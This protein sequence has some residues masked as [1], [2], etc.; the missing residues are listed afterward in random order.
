MQQ[1]HLPI[2]QLEILLILSLCGGGG[3]VDG[4]VKKKFCQKKNLVHKN[5]VPQKIGSQNFGQNRVIE[6]RYCWYGQMSP[7][8]MLPGQMSPWQ[9]KSLL[10]VPRYLLLNFGQ[11]R[12]SNSW[13]IRWGF[14]LL[15]LHGK[16]TPTPNSNGTALQTGTEIGKKKRKDW[17]KWLSTYV[18][19]NGLAERPPTATPIL[20]PW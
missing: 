8:E 10:D 9:L 5:W 7:G 3:W 13:D 6:L 18:I 12:V 16:L 4:W 1:C 14:F 19:A 20:V 17:S 11:N 2:F 15:L